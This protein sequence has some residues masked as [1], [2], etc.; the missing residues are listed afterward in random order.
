MRFLANMGISRQTV[1]FLDSLGHD[2]MYLHDQGLDQLPDSYILE[3]AR[4]E[5]RILLTH[6]LDSGEL[7]A[8]S[9]AKL[10]SVIIFRLRRMRPERVNHYLN[11]IITQHREALEQGAIVSITEGHIRVRPLPFE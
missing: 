11:A 4:S 6:D 3:K 1:A 7:V 5:G 10:P 8:A 9:R 2:A